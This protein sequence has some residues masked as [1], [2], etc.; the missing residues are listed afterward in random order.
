[1]AEQ[2]TM[3]HPA[4]SV[5]LKALRVEVIKGPDVGK[6]HVASTDRLTIGTAPGNDVQLTDETVSRY[7]LELFREGAHIVV[8]D[9]GSTNGTAAGGV[10]IER[11]RIQAG[12]VLTLGRT[13]IRIDDGDTLTLE[14][15]QSDDL[16]GLRGKSAEMR[17]LMAQIEKAAHSDVSVLILGETGT[18]KEVI[19]HALHELSPRAPHPF[20]TVDCGALLPTLI[21][22]ELFGHEKGAFT[23]ADQQHIG[24]FERANKGTLFLDEIGEL[25]QAV[26]AAL[27]GALERRSFRRLGGTAA[28][29]VNVRVISATHRDLR[30]EVNAGTFRQDLFFRLAVLMLRVPPLRDRVEDVP[31]LVE[32]FM[33]EAG[34]P[35]DVRELF[36]ESAMEMLTKHHW[37]GNVRELKNFIEAALAMG[38]AP[39]L[40]AVE[41]PRMRAKTGVMLESTL[42]A[43]ALEALLQ[44]A[45][46]EARG[47]VLRDFEGF[48]FKRLLEK[49]NGNVSKAAR[50]AKMD[51]SYLIQILKRHGLG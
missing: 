50:E 35:G 49:T 5:P 27:L 14:L 40:Q 30:S 33:R 39:E 32:H 1:V 15:N 6:A 8:Q 51:R 17:R 36:P 28:I 46:G 3:P 31:L 20:E 9:H 4:S 22:S 19:A 37:P 13:Q 45:Y 7:H 16:G 47:A 10:L 42:N 26:Q 24:A 18:G 43:D 11:G 21:A 12:T 29:S 44:V 25:P 41:R 34:Y 38:E 2:L 48:Y 23:G